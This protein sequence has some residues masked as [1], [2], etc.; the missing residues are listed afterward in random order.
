MHKISS[1]KDKPVE[2]LRVLALAQFGALLSY[3]V[4]SVKVLDI[5]KLGTLLN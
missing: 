4:P 1:V 5:N 3:E 2:I